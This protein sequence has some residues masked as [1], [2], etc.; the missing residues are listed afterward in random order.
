MPGVKPL[1]RIQLGLETTAGTAVV[2][3]TLWRGNGVLDETSEITAVEEDVGLL[4]AT[5]RS[6]IA[7][8][9]GELT[10]EDTPATFEQL[11]YILAAAVES[12]VTGATDGTQGSGKIY[13]YDWGT[14]AAQTVKTL[15]VEMGD[16]Q[17][18]DEMEYAHVFEFA[19]SG[20]AGEALMMSATWQGR[21][22]VDAEFTTGVTI[23]T[24]EEILFQ[25][26]TVK[27]DDTGGTIGTTLKTATVLGFTMNARTGN[28]PIHAADG[29]L[30]FTS[31]KNTGG[32]ITGE[33]T[34][35]H[36]ATGEAELGKARTEA[37]R[38][39]RLLFQGSALSTPGTAYT[40]KT[41]KIDMTIQYTE[42]PP[43]SDQDNNDTIVLPYRGVWSVADA[44]APQIIVV[45]ENTSLA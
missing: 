6:Y 22:V 8:K 26:G 32:E 21:Q 25:K 14:N 20:A 41:L 13:Q 42:L 17:R 29:N 2:A 3:T 9:G 45:N 15:T 11:P 40:Y 37:L 16:D 27:I 38:L 10:M 36:D 12:V 4:L 30:Y 1:R 44:I 7:Q 24:V 43:I 18:V 34:F 5:H 23:P 35:E 33:L 19:L 28:V 31:I 39:M